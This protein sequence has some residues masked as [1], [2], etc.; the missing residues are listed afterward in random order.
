M[1]NDAS[2]LKD[3]VRDIPDYPRPGVTFKDITPLLADIK[4]FRYSV[5]A[6]SDHFAGEKVDKVL[7]IEARGFIV[8]APVA[9]R[10][11]A[12]FVPVRKAGKLPWNVEAQEYVLEYGTDSLEIHR[13]ALGPGDHAL[14][15]DDVL[16]TG[17]TAAAATR[18]VER[19]G[20]VTI[21]AGFLIELT[22]L[23][24]RG[25]LGGYDAVSLISYE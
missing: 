18:L 22:F 14:I 24:G 13:D 11:G 15:I 16:A 10:F 1:A 6:L 2:W 20:G 12:G 25:K 9:Y 7:G 17:G 3:F 19:L 21:G 23:G 4:A 8:A 5:D